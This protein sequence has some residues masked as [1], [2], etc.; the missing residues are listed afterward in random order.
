MDALGDWVVFMT[1]KIEV[2][3]NSQSLARAA[4]THFSDVAEAAVTTQHR[5]TVALAGGNTPRLT[6]QLLTTS[7]FTSMVDWSKTFVFWGDERCVPPQDPE[8]NY[9]MARDYLLDYVKMPMGNI[10]RMKGEDDPVQAAIDYEEMLRKFFTGAR[11][12][13]EVIRPRFDLVMLGLGDDGH[14]ASLFP[15]TD[16]LR[17]RD[18]WAVA[19]YV[20]AKDS[21]RLT[22][23]PVALNSAA[24][25][26]FIVSG[27]SKA[28]MLRKILHEDVEADEY[29]AKLIQPDDGEVLWLVDD[30]A[31]S[32]L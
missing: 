29:P 1:R 23:T 10:Y 28:E 4:A 9:H 22:L 30:A 3:S 31:A 21:W 8:S 20:E 32:K 14:T 16:A 13:D 17:E 5:F 12:D 6:Y 15:G 26:I 25:V 2:Y 19:N 24:Q 7:E 27:A 18:R 11:I